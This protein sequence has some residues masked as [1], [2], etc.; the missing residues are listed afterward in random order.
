MLMSFEYGLDR[1]DSSKDSIRAIRFSSASCEPVL[2]LMGVSAMDRA[3]IF[4]P[5]MISKKGDF[6]PLQS[7]SVNRSIKGKAIPD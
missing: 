6:Q 3:A 2:R 1:V 4:R 5:L 7:P